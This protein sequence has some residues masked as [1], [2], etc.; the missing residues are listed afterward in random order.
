MPSGLASVDGVITPQAQALIPVSD[1]GLLRGDGVFEAIRI[2]GGRPFAL[3][4][5]LARMRRS[6]DGLRLALDIEAL[7]VEVA[8]MLERCEDGDDVLRLLATRGGRRIILLES[9]PELPKLYALARVTYSPGRVLDGVKSLSY[10]ANM[11]ALRLA[12]ERGFDDALLVT[13]HDRVLECSTSSFF[14]VIGGVLRTPP[15]SEHI[16]DS[17]TRR[18]VLA[19][20]D[21]SEE[22]I[23]VAD[24][25]QVE[26]AFIASSVREVVGVERIEDRE[27]EAP[28]PL[29]REVADL[30]S[31]RILAGLLA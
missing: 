9:V 16:L 31:E 24:L 19:V 4:D 14:A 28:G 22:P 21:V 15:L 18:V 26:E 5:H 27:L 25:E 20:G 29:T 23:R 2:Y 11:L 17:I 1:H 8:A 6:A 3:D 10:A 30:V 12:Q 13:P 7:R